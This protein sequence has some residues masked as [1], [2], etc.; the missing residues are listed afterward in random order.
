MRLYPRLARRFAHDQF[1]RQAALGLRELA[2]SADTTHPL[3]TWPATGAVRVTPT[4]LASLRTEVV[5]AAEGYG[6]PEPLSPD[7]QRALDLTLAR[8]LWDRA[9]LTPAEA[10]FGDVWSFLSLVLLP[11]VVWWRAGT[12]TNIE[13]FVATD[14]TRHTLA[15]LWWRALLFTHG[16]ADPEQGW[17]LWRSSDIGE[18]DLDQIQTRRGGYG[19]SPKVFR[20]LV[21]LYPLVTELAAASGVD[22]RSL[23]RDQYLRWLLRLG[24]FT[25]FSGLAEEQLDEDLEALAR[26][27][28]PI[29][30]PSPGDEEESQ[31]LNETDRVQ[32]FDALALRMVVVHLAQAVRSNGELADDELY[33]AFERAAG[34][35]VPPGR[36]EILFGIAWQG[37]PLHYLAHEGDPG[38]SKWRPGTVLPAPDR[39][40]G[41]WSIDSFKAHVATTNGDMDREALAAEL[42]TGR[43]GRTVRRIVRAAI[44]ETRP[45]QR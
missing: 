33:E 4:Q 29:P 39:R 20:A 22:R 23:W 9:E 24:A 37:V 10:G 18:A 45:R 3:M 36:R 28:E 30:E 15:R 40:W 34:I 26:Q 14:L 17:E 25:D 11:D 35:P 41:D 27:L 6:W 43:A 1:T 21:R 7:Q 44:Q 8:I 38:A 5:E 32:D 13:R 42:F 16:L 12:S 31:L 19:R 2:E